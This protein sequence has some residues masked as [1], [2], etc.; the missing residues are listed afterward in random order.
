M[1]CL[2]P[3]QQGLQGL[4]AHDMFASMWL[5]KI[6]YVHEP[7]KI[8][9]FLFVGAMAMTVAGNK[10]GVGK[11]SKGDG[12]GNKGVRQGTAIATKRA[13]DTATRVVGKEESKGGK[14]G[15]NN[16]EVAGD[17][18][19]NGKGGKSNGDDNKDCAQATG[20]MAMATATKRAMA[21]VT[22][23]W[24]MKRTMVRA[25][26][27]M[28]MAMRRAGNKEAMARAARATAMAMTVASNKKGKGEGDKG[29]DNSNEDGKQ[30]RGQ[31]QGQQ[32]QWQ[33]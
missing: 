3:D 32:E 33:W 12:N 14:G 19:S 7:P 15:D 28:A 6:S 27:A 20:T 1:I 22:M 24:A 21:M 8:I 2:Q 17:K 25:A 5:T 11:G 31:W 29:N 30:Q 26:R 4:Q 13:I 9:P 18:E 10:E 16:Y 23:W